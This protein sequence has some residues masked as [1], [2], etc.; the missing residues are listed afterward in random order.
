MVIVIIHTATILDIQKRH[1]ILFNFDLHRAG[2]FA[3]H[4]QAHGIHIEHARSEIR[5]RILVLNEQAL[6]SHSLD[7]IIPCPLAA[8]VRF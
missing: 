4:P 3:A 6:A 2:A 7:L 5:R 1:H 8:C